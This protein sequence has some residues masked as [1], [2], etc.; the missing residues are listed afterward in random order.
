MTVKEAV[1]KELATIKDKHFRL[2]KKANDLR[3]PHYGGIR[4]CIYEELTDSYT[5]LLK[6]LN[7]D[8]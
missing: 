8:S 1:E 7:R 6:D 2:L 3:D 4:L 5:R